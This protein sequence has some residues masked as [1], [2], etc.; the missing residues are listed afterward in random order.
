MIEIF[1][2]ESGSRYG[3]GRSTA[4]SRIEKIVVTVPMPSASVRTATAANPGLRASQR[5]E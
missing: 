4:A 3:S 1:T 2:R 5:K